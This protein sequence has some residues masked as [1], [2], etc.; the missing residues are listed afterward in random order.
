M[1]ERDE[2]RQRILERM[3]DYAPIGLT[4]D[5]AIEFERLSADLTVAVDLLYR[6]KARGIDGPDLRNDVRKF[7]SMTERDERRARFLEI[8]ESIGFMQRR[9]DQGQGN[10]TMAMC[11]LSL[12]MSKDL[13]AMVESSE[14]DREH[15]AALEDKLIRLR[16]QIPQYAYL[17][18]DGSWH[19]QLEL[20]MHLGRELAERI[21][22]WQN[23]PTEDGWYW[24]GNCYDMPW[25]YDEDGLVEIV[26]DG[27]DW[28]CRDRVLNDGDKYLIARVPQPPY[29]GVR[30]WPLPMLEGPHWVKRTNGEVDAVHVHQRGDEW[31]EYEKRLVMVEKVMPIRVPGYGDAWVKFPDAP[32][33]YVVGDPESCFDQW[34]ESFRASDGLVRCSNPERGVDYFEGHVFFG[35]LVEP[36]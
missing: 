3:A 24:I 22:C 29:E 5:V 16:K 23:Q 20:A 25:V 11:R 32:G 35:P 18:D 6:S 15:M 2:G 1:S 31:F 33:M 14:V 17:G 19:D 7:L 9:L 21:D 26:K 36:S 27:A 8:E 30:W 4:N 34:L 13:L 28:V 10:V 12:S